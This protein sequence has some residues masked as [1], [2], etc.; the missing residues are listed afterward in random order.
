MQRVQVNGRSGSVARLLALHRWYEARSGGIKRPPAAWEVLA[1][2]A[3]YLL[4]G[5]VV[6]ASVL[7]LTSSAEPIDGNA[8]QGVLVMASVCTALM[9][10]AVFRRTPPAETWFVSHLV[11]L[12]TTWAIVALLFAGSLLILALVLLTAVLLPF[13]TLLVYTPFV[14]AWSC[15]AWFLWR[16]GRGYLVLLRRG[17]IGSFGRA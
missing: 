17:P 5:L 14:L 12:S 2:H 15:A 10:W 11:W 8:F 13:L 9:V 6:V 1:V 4:S 16:V 3:L 7:A